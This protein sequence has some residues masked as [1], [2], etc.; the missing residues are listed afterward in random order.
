MTKKIVYVDMDNVLVDFISAKAK[1]PVDIWDNTEDKDEIPGIFALMDPI[2][3]AIDAYKG[4]CN[5]YDVYILS[6]SPWENMT[7]MNEKLAWVKQHLGK[8]AYKR[9]IV[10]HNKHL[11]KGDYLIDDRPNNGA[12]EFEGEWIQFGSEKFPDWQSVLKYLEI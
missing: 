5:K 1:L 9:L 11:N 2:D 8:H 7:A 6:T 4:L 12:S 3:G 10:S